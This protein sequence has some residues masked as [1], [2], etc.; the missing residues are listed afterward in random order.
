MP[1]RRLRLTAAADARIEAALA[2]L[3]RQLEI[4]VGFPDERRR[5]SRSSG[6]GRGAPRRGRDGGPLR[7]DRPTG[8]DGPRSGAPRRAPRDGLPRAVRDRRRHGVRRAREPARRGGAPPRPDALRPRWKRTPV[9]GR[10]LRG[11]CEP[12]TGRTPPG[13]RLDDGGGRDRRRDRRPRPEGARPE[14]CEAELRGRPAR[15]RRRIGRRRARAPARGRDPPP[16]A[17]SP[18]RRRQSAAPRAGG[19]EGRARVRPV[20]PGA[21]PGRG[22]ERADL[23]DDRDGGGGA[24]GHGRSRD[25]P[26][27]SACR[28]GAAR[29]VPAHGGGTRRPVAKGDALP[30]VPPGARR[31]R[32]AAGCA[33]RAGRRPSA[34]LR[35]HVLRPRRSRARRSC[36]ARIHV[37]PHDRAAPA[38]GRP[39]RRRDVRRA[40]G[41]PAGAG[42]GRV[43]RCRRCRS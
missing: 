1:R 33:A 6:T 24:D 25:P 28:P 7:H 31:E 14:P 10:T 34:R 39:L 15:A 27:R 23:A 8:V 20:L 13:A 19:G 30:R 41:R 43:R 17:G 36:R 38:A 9:S 35:L 2:E 12:P 3:R 40:V 16:T 42:V 4:V 11:S 37:R 18:P 5:R 21:V 32:P 26:H 22:M 29:A